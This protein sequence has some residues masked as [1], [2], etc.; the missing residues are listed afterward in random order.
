VLTMSASSRD[1][2]RAWRR[3]GWLARRQV[4]RR[5][6][7]TCLGLGSAFRSAS[8]RPAA[9]H[10]RC[11]PKTG[12]GNQGPAQPL[13]RAAAR[14]GR[15]VGAATRQGHV[16]DRR[17][18]SRSSRRF[19]CGRSLI[20]LERRPQRRRGP[21]QA[22][23]SGGTRPSFPAERW[24]GGWPPLVSLDRRDAE[25][26]L[27]CRNVS[28]AVRFQG[29]VM[30]RK[31]LPS[32][33][34]ASGDSQQWWSTRAPTFWSRFGVRLRRTPNYTIRMARDGERFFA[35]EKFF[36]IFLASTTAGD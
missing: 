19:V 30:I 12:T 20:H 21:S 7:P 11:L 6:R 26:A 33:S 25:P 3:S 17:A 35:C 23:R 27:G 18:R 32:R 34:R 24:T 31:W 28:L 22:P 14:V 10:R 4:R 1:A 36:A 15:S 16:A 5:P 8:S 13:L 9:R 29:S 2:M